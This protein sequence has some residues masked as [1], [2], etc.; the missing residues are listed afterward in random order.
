MAHNIDENTIKQIAVLAKLTVT[1][2][3]VERYVPQMKKIL[4]HFSELESL[5]TQHVDPLIT[6]VDLKSYMREDIA[7]KNISTEELLE[8]APEKVGALFKVP[9]VI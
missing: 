4:D 7:V 6:P 8:T 3:E 2:A 9:P 1:E 5:D